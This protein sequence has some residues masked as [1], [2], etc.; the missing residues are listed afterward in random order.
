MAARIFL[1]GVFATAAIGKLLDLPT[2][3]ASLRAFGVPERASAVIGTALPFGELSIAIAALL[4]PAARWAALG[5]LLLLLAFIAGIARVMRR[6]EAP[7]CSCFGALRSAPVGKATLARNIGLAAIATVALAW[8][9][10][11]A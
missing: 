1:A 3:R 7:P 10:G 2:S 9:P 8:G 5:A 4:E 6:G 11:S